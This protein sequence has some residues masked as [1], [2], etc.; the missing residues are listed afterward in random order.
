MTLVRL[1]VGMCVAI[2]VVAVFAAPE[3]A[4]RDTAAGDPIRGKKVFDSSVPQ[5]S[6]C[7][8]IRGRGGKLGPDLTKVGVTRNAA[9]LTK[10]LPDPRATDPVS[11]MP[12]VAA[13]G[14]ELDDL[15]AYLMTLKGK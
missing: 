3:T 11:K 5:C 1:L 7:H 14:K 12:A 4:A 6:L 15:V 9:W 8:T 10:F 13:K 2:A